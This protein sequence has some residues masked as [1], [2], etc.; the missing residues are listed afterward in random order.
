MKGELGGSCQVMSSSS[1]VM[2]LTTWE[3]SG[4]NGIAIL[5]VF[6][7]IHVSRPVVGGLLGGYEKRLRRDLFW[8]FGKHY[9]EQENLGSTW[10]FFTA[11]VLN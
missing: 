5:S 1:V 6:F 11:P 4:D 10:Q 2:E 8:C 3:G 9:D 7:G